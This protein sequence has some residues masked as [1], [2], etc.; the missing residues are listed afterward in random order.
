MTRVS[1][2]CVGL[3]VT[4]NDM[5]GETVDYGLTEAM[6]GY[7][8]DGSFKKQITLQQFVRQYKEGET[9]IT[10]DLAPVQST[11]EFQPQPLTDPRQVPETFKRWLWL[12]SS[13]QYSCVTVL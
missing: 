5:N 1:L 6:A 2:V 7:L 9:I 12:L 11:A 4:E 8:F 13:T 10:L 3:S